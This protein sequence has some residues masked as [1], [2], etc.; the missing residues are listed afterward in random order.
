MLEAVQGIQLVPR[1]HKAL[2][3]TSR[4]LEL[5]LLVHTA[6]VLEDI[7]PR[8]KVTLPVAIRFPVQVV[9]RVMWPLPVRL[10]EVTVE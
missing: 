10:T 6:M 9:R 3:V 5:Q 1:W 4:V 8:G 7:L 2:E